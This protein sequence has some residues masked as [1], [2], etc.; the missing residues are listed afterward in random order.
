MVFIGWNSTV[1]VRQKFW[2]FTTSEYTKCGCTVN[3]SLPGS[4]RISSPL[5]QVGIFFPSTNSWV[6][7]RKPRWRQDLLYEPKIRMHYCARNLQGW[8]GGCAGVRAC[9]TRWELIW[10]T[11]PRVV[12]PRLFVEVRFSRSSLVVMDLKLWFVEG[13]T[14]FSVPNRETDYREKNDVLLFF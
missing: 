7:L 5:Y 2:F 13:L 8:G 6:H 10:K 3:N 11:T 4:V 1:I 12:A 9:S 14:A